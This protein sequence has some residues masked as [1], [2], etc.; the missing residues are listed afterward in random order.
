MRLVIVLI[1]VMCLW[2]C[3]V[4]FSHTEPA[5]ATDESVKTTVSV[6]AEVKKAATV[7]EEPDLIETLESIHAMTKSAQVA[8]KTI[9]KTLG[10]Y[11]RQKYNEQQQR[12]ILARFNSAMSG[13]LASLQLAPAERRE[14]TTKVEEAYIRDS[15]SGTNQLDQNYFHD[16]P[17][18]VKKE[19]SDLRLSKTKDGTVSTYDYDGN[20][21]TKWTMR[22]GIPHGPAIT[23]YTSGEIK[24]ID[25]YEKGERV[26]RKKYDEEG[27]LIFEQDYTYEKKQELPI[28]IKKPEPAPAVKEEAPAPAVQ[29]SQPVPQKSE[30]A[31]EKSAAA[32]ETPAP[33]APAAAPPAP[34]ETA[35]PAAAKS[36]PAAE[37]SAK[38]ESNAFVIPVHYSKDSAEPSM[39]APAANLLPALPNGKPEDGRIEVIFKETR[40][41]SV[42][43][44]T[45]NAGTAVQTQTKPL[46]GS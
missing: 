23:Y 33:I 26:S 43:N 1:M 3:T 28:E 42:Q 30:P 4:P 44:E 24:F 8:A 36:E 7:S 15:E 41:Q 39:P 46:L 35:A 32:A 10:Q 5:A 34:V 12:D 11:V 40:T 13:Q 25:L 19:Y 21:K 29:S 9:G 37:K 45:Q 6:P 27:K 20:V 16:L 38:E 31:A 22:E 17:A 2:V 18:V 14:L